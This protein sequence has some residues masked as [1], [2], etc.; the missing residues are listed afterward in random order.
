[1]SFWIFLPRSNNFKDSFNCQSVGQERLIEKL[2][3]MKYN[4]REYSQHQCD[5][6]N[7]KGENQM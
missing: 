4:E 7:V 5:A 3:L 6:V 1:M 2:F